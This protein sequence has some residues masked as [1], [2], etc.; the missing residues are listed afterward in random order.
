[1]PGLDISIKNLQKVQISNGL[2]SSGLTL[3]HSTLL[4]TGKVGNL[5]AFTALAVPALVAPPRE[6]DI[7][8]WC[9]AE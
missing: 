5:S 1:M 2:P 7:K 6:A 3:L 4:Q 9:P 8:S